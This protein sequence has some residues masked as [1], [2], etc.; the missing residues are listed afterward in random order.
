MSVWWS[1]AGVIHYDFM[2]PGSPTTAEI[3]CNQPGEMM[4]KLK[5][6][7]PRLVNRSTS[8]LLYDNARPYTAQIAVAK[9]QELDLELL[10]Y[11]PYSPDLAPTDYH[12]FRN[13]EN[14][15]IGKQFNSDNAVKLAPSRK[16]LILVLQYFI[17]PV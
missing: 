9:L 5:E 17:P 10:L 16:P 7:Q 2:K 14:F 15:I 12:F 4:Q 6:K 3:Y 8:I 13:L 11:P 1:S